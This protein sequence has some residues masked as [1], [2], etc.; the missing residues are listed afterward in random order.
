MQSLTHKHCRHIGYLTGLFI[1]YIT[2]IAV[3]NP[4]AFDAHYCYL[5]D[6][7][8][9]IVPTLLTVI[10]LYLMYVERCYWHYVKALF[11]AQINAFAHE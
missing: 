7:F 1:V 3:I 10:P 4:L 2:T 9:L 8:I 6:W 11:C 5:Y